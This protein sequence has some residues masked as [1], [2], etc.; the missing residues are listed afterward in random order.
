MPGF[1]RQ[2]SCRLSPR[3]GKL[4]GVSSQPDSGILLAVLEELYKLIIIKGIKLLT[5][6]N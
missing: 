6:T 4:L 1:A 3:A 5:I 2:T